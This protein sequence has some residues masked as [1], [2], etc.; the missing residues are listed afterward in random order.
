VKEVLDIVLQP[1]RGADIPYSSKTLQFLL[2]RKAVSASMVEGGLLNALMLRNDWV[3]LHC[4]FPSFVVLI[5]L[6]SNRFHTALALYRTYP[7]PKL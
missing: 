4:V 2:E 7:R 1:N 5:I 3:N 6:F